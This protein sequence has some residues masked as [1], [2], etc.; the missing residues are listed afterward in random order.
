MQIVNHFELEHLL[1]D[2]DFGHTLSW[3]SKTALLRA[4][5]WETS[6]EGDHYWRLRYI[7]KSKWTKKARDSILKQIG[8]AP[9]EDIWI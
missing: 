2:N 9:S 8:R 6:V 3:R 5:D 1:A 4:F 7:G